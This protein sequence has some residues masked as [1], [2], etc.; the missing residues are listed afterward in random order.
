MADLEESLV[1]RIR[2]D[3]T[4]EVSRLTGEL[5]K[6]GATARATGSAGAAGMDRFASSIGNLAAGFRFLAAG[7]IGGAVIA[8]FASILKAGAEAQETFVHLQ[9]A[10]EGTGQTFRTVAGQLEGYVQAVDKMSRFD[11]EAIRR[12][13]TTLIQLGGEA[14]E[15]E[16]LLAATADLAVARHLKMEQASELV[17]RALEGQTT[18]LRRA[19]VIFDE[20]TQKALQLGTEEERVAILTQH[21]NDK[22]GG[23]AQKDLKTYTGQMQELKNAIQ[24]FRE[25]LGQRFLDNF[26]KSI[27]ELVERARRARVDIDAIL[28]KPFEIGVG[29][30]VGG[31]AS[32]ARGEV[33][34][35]QQQKAL[36][37][38]QREIGRGM[39]LAIVDGAKKAAPR[40][41]KVIADELKRIPGLTYPGPQSLGDVL[42]GMDRIP[43][44]G[45]DQ[46]A[47]LLKWQQDWDSNLDS[48]LDGLDQANQELLEGQRRV[49]R[50]ISEAAGRRFAEQFG[51]P[52]SSIL[53]DLATTGGR[54]FGEI[55][56][57][58]LQ[59]SLQTGADKITEII[60]DA[61]LGAFGAQEAPAE[62]ETPA[63]TTARTQRN[64]TRANRIGSVLQG[65]IASIGV[66]QANQSGQMNDTQSII[67][68][69]GIGA[70]IGSAWP[71]L[72]T[73]IGA[74]VGAIIGIISA[75]ASDTAEHYKYASVGVRG[76]K[77]FVE[78][79][80][81]ESKG[82]KNLTAA[83]RDDMTARIQDIFDS[84]R[85]S[86]VRLFLKF[87]DDFRDGLMIAIR[88]AGNVV[89]QIGLDAGGDIGGG[90]S[91]NFMKHFDAW[92]SGELPRDIAQTFFEPLSQAFQSYGVSAGRFKQIWDQLS[93]LDP[94][95]IADILGQLADAV[96]AF[97]E[98]MKFFQT[99]VLPDY[100]NMQFGGGGLLQQ[101]AGENNRSFA[102]TL[103]E[104]D[105]DIIR[106]GE[107]LSTLTGEGQI[108]AAQELGQM[109][110]DRMEKERRFLQEVSDGIKSITDSFD[111]AIRD[112][113][114]QG[115][116]D[117]EGNP[118]Y[119]AQVDYLKNY[120]EGLRQ[121]LGQATS[122]ADIQALSQEM[123]RTVL[124]I[125]QVGGAA[126]GENSEN[127]R[128][129]ALDQLATLR[130]ES[131]D[132]M[133]A[134]AREVQDAN[135]SFVSAIQGFIDAFLDAT[136]QLNGEPGTGDTAGPG[137]GEVSPP[138]HPITFNPEQFGVFEAGNDI[139]QAQLDKLTEIGAML[140]EQGQQS[141]Q[142]EGYVRIDGPDGYERDVV[143]RRVQ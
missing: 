70:S 125:Q 9:T 37:D 110:E 29:G 78:A 112:L 21:L 16:K 5:N 91:A 127:Y 3:G 97:A 116:T 111:A 38:M 1:I 92:V 20:T 8:T 25:G 14:A 19:G 13:L 122:P 123:L 135:D 81:G 85:N 54:N 124:Q 89:P 41:A 113:T 53:T 2:T 119:Q 15:S 79:V 4:L 30:R 52:F 42:G 128:Q 115:M 34:T 80:P 74:V 86:F 95:K 130:Q 51:A 121:Q 134:L 88:N 69:I 57:R 12:G 40:V 64:A 18:A 117:K 75:V 23:A 60:S 24:D 131:V 102:D 107:A 68:Q 63:Q 31:I 100:S 142:V 99:P 33:A 36:Q 65:S 138:E 93:A 82:W 118:D 105:Q 84:V 109:L 143:L 90:A 28:N 7:A 71:G 55:A 49:W 10:V 96:V 141:V 132:R 126:G 39:E 66:I 17:G 45:E 103:R 87:P 32:V 61:I 26:D 58:S 62:G 11:D 72:G 94:K 56:G 140:A 77:A 136:G 50:E 120:L 108:A 46:M 67:S 139:S 35:A 106:L 73:A 133:L 114:L 27:M 6:L 137:G 98:T 22:F 101:V 83:E 44:V 129:W 43:A 48:F 59:D 76:G 47:R 104:S